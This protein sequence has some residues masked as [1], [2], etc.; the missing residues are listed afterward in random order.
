VARRP[1]RRARIDSARNPGSRPSPSPGAEVRVHD[2]W[3]DGRTDGWARMGRSWGN[4][5]RRLRAISSTA[6]PGLGRPMRPRMGKYALGFGSVGRPVQTVECPCPSG[7]ST[8]SASSQ[9]VVGSQC[10]SRDGYAFV[11][12]ALQKKLIR[13]SYVVVDGDTCQC[14]YLG[15]PEPEA[16]TSPLRRL[17]TIDSDELLSLGS[18]PSVATSR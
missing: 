16:T 15:R 11:K 9:S 2:G 1:D 6:A 4:A 5:P 13:R 12:H 17:R 8:R 14:E 3:A 10:R 18:I 7:A